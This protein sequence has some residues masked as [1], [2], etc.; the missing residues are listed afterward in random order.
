MKHDTTQSFTN[1]K[2]VILTRNSLSGDKTKK[3]KKVF[4]FRASVPIVTDAFLR[5]MQSILN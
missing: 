3:A 4:I 2:Q 1:R 5:I